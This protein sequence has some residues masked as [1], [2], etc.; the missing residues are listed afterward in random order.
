MN[1]RLKV[2][3]GMPVDGNDSL[4]KAMEALIRVR[5]DRRKKSISKYL[6]LNKD[7]Y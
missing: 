4:R 1:G 2:L 3:N 5:Q 6:T 7:D